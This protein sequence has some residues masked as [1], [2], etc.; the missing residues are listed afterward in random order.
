MDEILT[1]LPSNTVYSNITMAN[2]TRE[3]ATSSI[4][5]S[6]PTYM[7]STYITT[8]QES[9][10]IA[11]LKADIIELQN[12]M[13]ALNKREAIT[14]ILAQPEHRKLDIP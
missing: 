5:S 2:T 11:K 13:A 14:G 10:E 9:S 8:A 6:Y 12:Q 4:T 3:W 7:T 1:E